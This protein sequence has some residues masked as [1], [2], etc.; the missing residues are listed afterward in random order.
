MKFGKGFYCQ[1]NISFAF[2]SIQ[3]SKNWC[4]LIDNYL[5]IFISNQILKGSLWIIWLKVKSFSIQTWVYDKRV[6]LFDEIVN[7]FGFFLLRNWNICKCFLKLILSEFTVDYYS[8]SH[9]NKKFTK[10]VPNGNKYVVNNSPL[11]F[12]VFFNFD[13]IWIMTIIQNLPAF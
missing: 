13:D 1:F 2:K 4:L 9:S 7:W 8:V 12:I 10:Y 6:M 5:L 3:R 11:S